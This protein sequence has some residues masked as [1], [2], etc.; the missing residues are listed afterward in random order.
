MRRTMLKSVISYAGYDA[1]EIPDYRP[2]VVHVDAGNQI[3]A[4]DAEVA[5]LL[6]P[7]PELDRVI[8]APVA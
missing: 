4:T 8:P 3:V 2:R 1:E 5:T 6:T 7:E